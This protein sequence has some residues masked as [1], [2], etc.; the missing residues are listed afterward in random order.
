VHLALVVL[1]Q[2]VS[3]IAASPHDTS[4]LSSPRDRRTALAP[5]LDVETAAELLPRV[6]LVGLLW[7]DAEMTYGL[8]GG[9]QEGD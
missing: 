2:M 5:R 9:S 8:R 4:P 3:A 6:H 1:H 7:F